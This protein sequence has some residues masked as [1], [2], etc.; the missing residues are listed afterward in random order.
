MACFSGLG[1]YC[2]LV[3]LNR[4]VDMS[5]CWNLFRKNTVSLV[6]CLNLCVPFSAVEHEKPADTSP[7]VWEVSNAFLVKDLPKSLC[8]PG[9]KGKSEE[10]VQA[11][12]AENN[13][14]AY[15]R[16]RLIDYWR[17]AG[18]LFIKAQHRMGGY[19]YTSWLESA[20]PGSFAK[21]DDKEMFLPELDPLPGYDSLIMGKWEL[22]RWNLTYEEPRTTGQLVIDK[23]LGP[24]SYAGVFYA[25]ADPNYN[26]KPKSPDRVSPASQG[27]LN[28]S[29]KFYYKPSQR[30]GQRGL[31]KNRCSAQC[32]RLIGHF[33]RTYPV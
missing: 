19:V 26:L 28:P 27:P 33:G 31:I 3:Y 25:V 10:K 29:F 20:G 23:R 8:A 2:L 18:R 6:L 1:A 15:T 11:C 4:E 21:D 16:V 12:F 32:Q 13:L 9:F 30:I 14:P 24:N 7:P 22:T 5:N 17:G